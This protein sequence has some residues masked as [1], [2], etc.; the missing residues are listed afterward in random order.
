VTKPNLD[1]IT[2]RVIANACRSMC[3]EMGHTM[4]NTA[5]STI[6]VEGRD[7]SCAIVDA[8]A[9]LVAAANFDPSHLSAMALT[10]EFTVLHF[11]PDNIRPGDVYLINDPYRGA[12]ICPTSR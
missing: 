2:Q 5:N 9:E 11:G 7:F 3:E 8:K 4:I 1:P 10:V 6:F 12:A